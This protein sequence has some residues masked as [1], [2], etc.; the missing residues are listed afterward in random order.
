MRA[1]S[2]SKWQKIL[3]ATTRKATDVCQKKKGYSTPE[4]LILYFGQ[5][6]CSARW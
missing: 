3:R 1:F 2:E 4:E 6:E 5:P